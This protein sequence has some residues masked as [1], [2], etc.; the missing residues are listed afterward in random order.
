MQFASLPYK[1]M[2]PI[3]S[4][5]TNAYLHYLQTFSYIITGGFQYSNCECTLAHFG[6]FVYDHLSEPI[7]FD[8]DSRFVYIYSAIICLHFVILIFLFTFF[9]SRYI[10]ICFYVARG[11][12][13]QCHCIWSFFH[14][15]RFVVIVN[16]ILFINDSILFTFLIICLPLFCCSSYDESRTWNELSHCPYHLA[17]NQ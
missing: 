1:L 9:C 16:Y 14:D 7:V 4:V 13:S 17:C 5:I 2:I 10:L 6:W 15:H 8:H 12:C 11:Y 3:Y